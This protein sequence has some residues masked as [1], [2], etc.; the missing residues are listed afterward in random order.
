MKNPNL[1]INA[2]FGECAYQAIQKHFKKSVKHETEVLQDKDPEP[3]H[4]MRVGMRRLRSAVGVFISA[5]DL[6]K[7]GE[8]KRIGKIASCLGNVRDLDV[9]GAALTSRYRDNLHGKERKR[10]DA[11][12]KNLAKQR[13]HDFQQLEQMLSSPLYEKFKEAFTTWLDEPSY[14]AIANLPVGEVLPDLMS[15]LISEMLL[16]PG[17]LVGATIENG[18]IIVAEDITPEIVNEYLEVESDK[19]H[20]LRKQMKRVRYQSEFFVDFYPPSYSDRVQNFKKIQEILGELQD[21][22]VLREFLTFEVGGNL[23]ESLPTLAQQLKDECF[24]LWQDWEPIRQ[25][26]FN[27]EIRQSLRREIMTPIVNLPDKSEEL[28]EGDRL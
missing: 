9:L 8:I 18:K 11:I 24:K 7:A 28:E 12:L 2:T 16:H 21:R 27:P 4:Q 10:F 25:H 3:L 14:K 22:W 26:Y 15:P 17:W 23:T 13:I 6:P 20:E 19:L 5:L 1:L